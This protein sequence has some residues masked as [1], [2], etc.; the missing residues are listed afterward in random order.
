MDKKLYRLL[1]VLPFITG[2]ALQLIFSLFAGDNDTFGE[3][4]K[5]GIST[6]S[7]ATVLYAGLCGLTKPQTEYVSMPFESVVIEGLLAGYVEDGCLA[8]VSSLCADVLSSS[9]PPEEEE[10]KL[11]SILAERTTANTAE[12]AMLVKIMHNTLIA[13]E[14]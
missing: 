6:G 13:T 8:E 5:E 11:L 2:V 3:I 9:L 1:S 12:A 10:E 4:L 14:D 7:A